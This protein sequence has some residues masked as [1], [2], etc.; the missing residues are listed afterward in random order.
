[1]MMEQ[2]S[3]HLLLVVFVMSV[4]FSTVTILFSSPALLLLSLE[5]SGDSIHR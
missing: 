1:M 4:A 5:H 3:H 2:K